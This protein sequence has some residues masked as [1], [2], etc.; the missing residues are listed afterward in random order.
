[1]LENIKI[2]DGYSSNIS[3]HVNSKD[4]R[5]DGLKT[6]DYHVLMQELILTGVCCVL[7]KNMKMTVIRLYNFY[8]DICAKRLLKKD[9]KK[10]KARVVTILCDVEKIF[11][12]WRPLKRADDNEH[13]Q[14]LADHPAS[15]AQTRITAAK[16]V[17]V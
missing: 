11:S 2:P 1:M 9:V 5:F 8:R 17:F 3:K 13:G 15:T 6:H 16:D 7:P 10:M 4:V 12:L 14:F